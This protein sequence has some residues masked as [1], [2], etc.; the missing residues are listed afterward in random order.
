[1]A[2]KRSLLDPQVFDQAVHVLANRIEGEVVPVFWSW[3]VVVSAII[4]NDRLIILRKIFDLM[5]PVID[6]TCN[7]ITQND[8]TPLA[9]DFVVNGCSIE[10]DKPARF[11]TDFLIHRGPPVFAYCQSLSRRRCEEILFQSSY[12]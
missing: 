9:A 11:F 6:Q 10:A 7:S 8:W 3:S 4:K 2:P 12:C 5:N 1:M